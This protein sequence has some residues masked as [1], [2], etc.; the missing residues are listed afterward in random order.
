M[1]LSL[2]VRDVINYDVWWHLKTGEWVLQHGDVPRT[3]PFSYPLA[4]QPWIDIHWLFQVVLYGLFKL[5]GF[6]ALIAFKTLVY[7]LT[8]FT[9]T[10]IHAKSGFSV[11][12]ALAFLLAANAAYERLVV[13]PEMMSAW[14]LAL[15]LLVLTNLKRGKTRGLWLLPLLQILWANLQGIF[16]LGPIVVAAFLLGEALLPLRRKLFPATEER[17]LARRDRKRVGMVF[18]AVVAACFVNPYTWRGALYPL[19]F[20][21][22]FGH[23]PLGFATTITEFISPFRTLYHFEAFY[24]YLALLL[25]SLAVVL[26]RFHRFHTWELG[27]Y[28][29]FV[30][31]SMLARRNLL[32]FAVVALP[33]TVKGWQSVW[34]RKRVALDVWLRPVVIVAFLAVSADHFFRFYEKRHGMELGFW[35]IRKD[36]YPERAVDFLLASDLRGN[37]FNDMGS[38]G[39]LI[40]RLAPERK[41]FIDGRNIDEELFRTYLRATADYHAF[42]TLAR[43][44]AFDY[45]LLEVRAP[46]LRELA[47]RL[48]RDPAWAQVYYDPGYEIFIK[49][50]PKNQQMILTAVETFDPP[51]ART[52]FERGHAYLK[53][54]HDQFAL[55]AFLQETRVNPGI[56]RA[57]VNCAALFERFGQRQQAETYYRLAY[58]RAPNNHLVVFALATFYDKQGRAEE[59]TALYRKVLELKPD[60][61]PARQRLRA[62][63]SPNRE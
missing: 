11:P 8:F 58:Q 15:F 55:K 24:W 13:R 6:P 51:E 31:L 46:Y 54:G 48:K 41:V 47:D 40:Y 21:K 53:M 52:P 39:Y 9:L 63:A 18:A 44:Y 33:L 49:D 3:D 60:F 17:P 19:Q 28:L 50:T 14:F 61:A 42:Q 16:I 56:A 23:E 4:D 5:G 36:S 7:G 45:A 26:W 10:R 62:L 57:Y 22:F 35:G 30:V 43:Q 25:L 1:L 32:F 59:A 29:F 37:L 2:L 27:V 34:E 12:V 38:G 20:F